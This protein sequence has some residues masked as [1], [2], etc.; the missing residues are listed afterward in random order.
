MMIWKNYWLAMAALD[1]MIALLYGEQRFQNARLGSAK[2]IMFLVGYFA[3]YLSSRVGNNWVFPCGFLAMNLL[4]LRWNY[5]LGWGRAAFHS[6]A[7]CFLNLL[8]KLSLILAFDLYGYDAPNSMN[9]QILE[10]IPYWHEGVYGVLSLIAMRLLL[11]PRAEKGEGE[12]PLFLCLLP[13]LSAA[14]LL[15]LFKMGETLPYSAATNAVV[16]MAAGTMGCANGL[17][18]CLYR[19]LRQ[20]SE[21]QFKNQLTI[22]KEQADVLYYSTLQTQADSQRILIH[23]IKNHLRTIDALAQAGENGELSTYIH[24]LDQSISKIPKAKLCTEPIL[25]V[26]LL[27]FREDCEREKVTFSCDVRDNCIGFMDE[28]GITSLFGNLLSNALEA[29]VH[30]ERRSIE[31]TVKWEATHGAVLISVVNSCDTPPAFD[32]QG[33]L[34]TR[35]AERGMHGI[36]LKSIRRTVSKYNGISTVKYDPDKQEFHH[37]IWLTQSA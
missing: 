35:K 28:I 4:L 7:L 19:L 11:P 14:A 6:C 34:V 2:M 5:R 30:S 15:L 18:I 37:V 26:L 13:L 1:G 23:D 8:S 9:Y 27:R 3:L 16:I 20:R 10:R 21:E 17:M 25:N 12:L 31:L 22:Q 32:G 36:G 29:A 24:Q 33:R